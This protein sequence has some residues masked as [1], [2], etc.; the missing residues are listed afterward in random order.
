MLFRASGQDF[1]LAYLLFVETK[2]HFALLNVSSSPSSVLH[3]F[4]AYATQQ[5]QHNR[6]RRRKEEKLRKD[7]AKETLF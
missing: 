1:F 3:L 5:Q 4:L 7:E 2:I 6:R